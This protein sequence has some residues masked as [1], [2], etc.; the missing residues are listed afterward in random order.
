MEFAATKVDDWP[1]QH[2]DDMNCELSS[3][4][5]PESGSVLPNLN[6]NAGIGKALW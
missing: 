4:S 5:S 6:A 1:R 2:K 3:T